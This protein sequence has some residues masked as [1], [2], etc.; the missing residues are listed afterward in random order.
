MNKDEILTIAKAIYFGPT[1]NDVVTPLREKLRDALPHSGINDL[2][3]WNPVELTPEQVVD[4]AIR[5]EAEY[6]CKVKQG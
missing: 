2:I 1:D 4:E 5:R 6:A 3:F